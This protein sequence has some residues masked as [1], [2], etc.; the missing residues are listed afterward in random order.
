MSENTITIDLTPDTQAGFKAVLPFASS[1]D[2]T[3]VL[4]GVQVT[5]RRLLATNRYAV[6][7]YTYVRGAEGDETAPFVVHRDLVDFIVKHKIVGNQRLI[8]TDAS[9]TI[10]WSD[11]SIAASTSTMN[12]LSSYNLPPVARL[13]PEKSTE[14][15]NHVIPVGINPAR[16]SELVKASAAL[17][18][19]TGKGEPWRFQFQQTEGTKLA[20]IRASLGDHMVALIQPN[21]LPSER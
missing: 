18:K 12:N 20:P 10:V 16:L 14:P 19:Q 9:A 1:D 6:G 13:I 21:L 15:V 4:C 8:L 11:D 7:A 2:I 17:V 5:D 3:P